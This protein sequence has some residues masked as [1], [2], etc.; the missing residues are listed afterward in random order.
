MTRTQVREGIEAL[1]VASGI[2]CDKLF[3]VGRAF[4][5]T[6]PTMHTPCTH[7]HTRASSHVCGLRMVLH[8][9]VR[10][11]V[12]GSR[13]SAHSN[14]YVTGVFGTIPTPLIALIAS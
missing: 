10:A 12:D 4:A 14:A 9:R 13:Q 5:C 7:A 3:E 1:V 11:Q 6:T 2:S 8:A